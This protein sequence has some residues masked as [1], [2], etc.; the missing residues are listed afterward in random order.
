MRRM[1]YKLLIIC[2]FLI[3]CILLIYFLKKNKQIEK[4]DEDDE[5]Q[6]KIIIKIGGQTSTNQKIFKYNNS[7]EF[8]R[9]VGDSEGTV[10][11]LFYDE[12]L[13]INDY[14]DP[15]TISD[16]KLTTKTITNNY[17]DII[18]VINVALD[19]TSYKT[20]YLKNDQKV[21]DEEES[22]EAILSYTNIIQITPHNVG[23]FLCLTNS[24][25]LIKITLEPNSVGVYSYRETQVDT[26]PPGSEEDPI[27]I[28]NTPTSPIISIKGFRRLDCVLYLCMNG[29]LFYLADTVSTQLKLNVIQFNVPT[30]S[31]LSSSIIINDEIRYS[32]I[33]IENN[34]I[35]NNIK[36]VY[37][38]KFNLNTRRNT[39]DDGYHISSTF[40]DLYSFNVHSTWITCTTDSTTPTTPISY[41]YY[42]IYYENN[43]YKLMNVDEDEWLTGGVTPTS[44]GGAGG[45]YQT[46]AIGTNE[47]N[48][49][50]IEN[51]T[52]FTEIDNKIKSIISYNNELYYLK[53][54]VMRCTPPFFT[55]TDGVQCVSCGSNGSQISGTNTCKCDDGF[56]VVD[57]GTIVTGSS[58][59]Y[60]ATTS[61]SG[62]YSCLSVSC[63]PG[64]YK[65][66]IDV[67]IHDTT[68]ECDMC[69]L[70]TGL[71]SPNAKIIKNSYTNGRV[72]SSNY[73]S[74][75]PRSNYYIKEVCTP[76]SDTIFGQVTWWDDLASG[77]NNY[78][79][80]SPYSTGGYKSDA[81]STSYNIIDDFN[82]D[83]YSFNS[84][85][86]SIAVPVYDEDTGVINQYAIN[87]NG[88]DIPL[89]AVIDTSTLQG[90]LSVGNDVEFTQCD[91]CGTFSDDDIIK[92]GGTLC[93]DGFNL[94]C[95]LCSNVHRCF[96]LDSDVIDI[97][98]TVFDYS[99]SFPSPSSPSGRT[100]ITGQTKINK[101]IEDCVETG[102]ENFQ[103]LFLTK[104]PKC[105]VE[106]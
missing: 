9:S 32:C 89:P 36:K 7:I 72:A 5:R 20:F 102:F 58:D 85:Y 39:F 67:D 82:T 40:D 28:E 57:T 97:F 48:N 15:T 93:T 41:Q 12:S 74:Y 33:A 43:E 17:N 86:K 14:D 101:I 99:T 60:S 62:C 30:D 100:T 19:T 16:P 76:Q 95:D 92:S 42:I 75:N 71:P 81:T 45:G 106:T 18:Q 103:S 65:T 56:N 53:N 29:D 98:N 70:C 94:N 73:T 13:T 63:P 44:G 87:R 26:T 1:L 88:S 8:V 51:I 35:E 96:K 55:H 27:L 66:N 83:L 54:G 69:Q 37:F 84:P 59:E 25:T 47:N 24:N 6:K 22:A 79:Y 4:F 3:L 38:N 11:A 10:E 23:Y 21:Y 90:L 78:Y 46:G 31:D 68:K 52:V 77:E 105:S 61:S 91:T 64:F 2:L 34:S 49:L 104:H 80:S 50:S